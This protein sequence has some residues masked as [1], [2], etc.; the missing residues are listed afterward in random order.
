MVMGDFAS[1]A[2]SAED[3]DGKIRL[4]SLYLT[5]IKDRTLQPERSS[6]VT[7]DQH[8]ALCAIP[9]FNVAQTEMCGVVLV[10]ELKS[11][12]LAMG[13]WERSLDSV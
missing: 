1:D 3:L 2:A 13:F 6:Y 9:K 12:M 10:T 7:S 8:P 5:R 4:H 11:L